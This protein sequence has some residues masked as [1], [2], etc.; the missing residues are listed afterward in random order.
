[1]AG[2]FEFVERNNRAIVESSDGLKY[3]LNCKHGLL[4]RIDGRLVDESG[5]R[6]KVRRVNSEDLAYVEGRL[7]NAFWTRVKNSADCRVIT[8]AI[9]D[10]VIENVEF[11]DLKPKHFLGRELKGVAA[12]PSQRAFRMETDPT[13][14]ADQFVSF[15]MSKAFKDAV[16]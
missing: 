7:G 2:E 1:M 3:V 6:L 16:K 5:T 11:K 4:P 15:K 13:I 14:K 12:H 9:R 8:G 10:W